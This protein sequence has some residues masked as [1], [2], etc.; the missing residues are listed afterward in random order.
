[1]DSWP[2]ALARVLDVPGAR[3]AC[4]DGPGAVAAGPGAPDRA[5]V[6][7]LVA[8]A[9]AE[10]GRRPGFE[11]AMITTERSHHL[12]RALP[13]DAVG[14]LVLD[15]EQGNLALARRALAELAGPG[16]TVAPAAVPSRAAAPPAACVPLP[17]PRRPRRPSAAAVA[18][19]AGTA[20]AVP[21]PRVPG[22]VPAP[23]GGRWADD[24]ATLARVLTALRRM[25][26]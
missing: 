12:L 4:V 5:T 2:D 20:A 14:Y 3:W 18:G 25:D 11:D 13:G 9:R 17:A 24:L 1:M 22:A 7:A 10:H 23:P 26:P 19:V 6:D 15:R 21:A 8:W 16:T